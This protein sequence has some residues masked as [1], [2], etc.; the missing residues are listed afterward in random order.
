[1][2]VIGSALDV[3]NEQDL[4]IDGPT[5]A[6]EF[7]AVG[8][9]HDLG[10]SDQNKYFGEISLF[11]K[12]ETAGSLS[13]I[14]RTGELN[15]TRAITQLYDMRKNRQ[16]LGRLGQG[17]HAQVELVNAEVGIDVELYGYEIDPVNIVGR[18]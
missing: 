16:R 3:Y 7:D 2:P 13:V 6:I 12:E 18:R 15:Q 17:K 4:R 9:R 14:S 11:G 1:M 5:T 10:D 8:K